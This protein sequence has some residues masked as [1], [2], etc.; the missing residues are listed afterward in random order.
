MAEEE[1]EEE[2]D[3]AE[4][5]RSLI[6]SLFLICSIGVS[7]VIIEINWSNGSTKQ[8]IQMSVQV[9]NYP[10]HLKLL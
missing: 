3:D 8:N 10:G 5:P 7:S 4:E 1:E 2:E 9:L 6:I